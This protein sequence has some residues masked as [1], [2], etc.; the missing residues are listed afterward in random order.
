[1]ISMR[2]QQTPC[3][4]KR[5]PAPSPKEAKKPKSMEQMMLDL[6]KGK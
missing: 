1:M 3:G 6:I 4:T 5:P 2:K